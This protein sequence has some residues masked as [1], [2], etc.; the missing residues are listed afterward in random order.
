M[1]SDRED[2]LSV[3]SSSMDGDRSNGEVFGSTPTALTP[4][5]IQR[6]IEDLFNRGP[7]TDPDNGEGNWDWLYN[8]TEPPS[9][10]QSVGAWG[11]D[12]PEI[13]PG[14]H[15]GKLWWFQILGVLDGAW[16]CVVPSQSYRDC[17]KAAVACRSDLAQGV[18][19]WN[20]PPSSTGPSLPENSSELDWCSTQGK[21]TP[22]PSFTGEGIRRKREIVLADISRV[23]DELVSSRTK[24]LELSRAVYS[25]G[26]DREEY[27]AI[28]TSIREAALQE[29][30]NRLILQR[31]FEDMDTLLRHLCFLTVV[32]LLYGA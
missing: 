30:E 16:T 25:I 7:G 15:E 20:D 5:Q 24:I 1:Q 31:E 13:P 4:V 11:W 23:H 26:A 29:N 22:L 21:D 32:A 6:K 17:M 2:T 14:Q 28:R 19:S 8:D 12:L 27:A 3:D 18:L 10:W 9:E